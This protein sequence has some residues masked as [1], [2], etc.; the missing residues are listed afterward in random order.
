MAAIL[1][2]PT[3]ALAAPGD[4]EY[5]ADQAAGAAEAGG[6]AEVVVTAERRS[7]TVQ[8][9]PIT[10]QAITGDQLSQMQVQT[11]DDVLKYLPN[12]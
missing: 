1:S 2:A 7:E 8:N 6:L 10:I 3:I 5:P 4:L 12:V 11:F 9:V